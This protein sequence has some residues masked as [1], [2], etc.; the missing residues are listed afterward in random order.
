[1]KQLWTIL[2]LA[3]ALL[4]S[5]LPQSG[6]NPFAG[7]WD[8]KVTT[9]KDTYPQWM[10]LVEKDGALQVRIQPRGGNVRPAVS[11]RMDGGRLIIVVSAATAERPEVVWELTASG[12]KFSG[13]QKVGDSANIQIAGVRA[14]ALK[15][16]APKAWTDPESLFNAKD[17]S[18]W[19]P[20]LGRR[21]SRWSVKDGELVNDGTGANIRTTRNFDDFKLHI[22]F[23]IP[24]RANSGLY[25]RGR[26][27]IQIGA[28][29]GGQNVHEMGSIYGFYPPARIVTAAPGTWQSFDVTLVGR[30]VTVIRNGIAI[31]ENVEIPG[32]T[33]GALDSD[34]GEPGPFYLQGDHDGVL[35]FRNIRISVPKR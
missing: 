2:A 19:E 3:L 27:E 20:I 31:H 13:V 22:D 11:T 14:P 8:I 15:R 16:E 18:G 29:R 1:M 30:I 23:N 33:G 7:R 28:D 12:D 25:L 6:G 9:P 32:I 10:E 21:Q 26:Y 17:L 35:R 24:E 5:A 4:I 34:E